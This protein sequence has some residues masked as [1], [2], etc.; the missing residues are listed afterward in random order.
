MSVPSDSQVPA[1]SSLSLTC[2]AFEGSGVYTY[3]WFSNCS[4]DC[5]ISGQMVQSVNRDAVRSTDS[6]NHTCSVVDDAGNSGSSS[7]F[8][9][10]TGK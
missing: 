8:I 10:I 5:L 9:S 6:G 1:G 4:G 7:V 2:Q 3:Q